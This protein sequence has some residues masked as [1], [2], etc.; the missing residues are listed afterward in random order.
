MVVDLVAFLMSLL[1]VSPPSAT[2]LW[3]TLSPRAYIPA[4]RA[5]TVELME[6]A[7]DQYVVQGLGN[8]ITFLRDVYRNK[9]FRSG[10]YSTKFIGNEYPEGFHG[11]QL[12]TSETT[13]FIALAAALHSARHEHVAVAEHSAKEGRRYVAQQ[14]GM[15]H[16]R[17]MFHMTSS[18]LPGAPAE[19]DMDANAGQ[20]GDNEEEEERAVESMVVVLGGPKGQ[21]YHVKVSVDNMFQADITPMNAAG[22]LEME[23]TESVRTL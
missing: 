9:V 1:V 2:F 6:H 20:Y 7:L 21:A 17:Q 19:E 8:N 5:R 4:H 16:A 22:E 14:T 11:V 18:T 23:K 13:E 15:S 3:L 10:N 12:T